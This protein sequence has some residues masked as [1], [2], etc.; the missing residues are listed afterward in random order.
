MH[1]DSHRFESHN[2]LIIQRR[3]ERKKKKY[4]LSFDIGF[5][6]MGRGW[7]L[8]I[9]CG[10]SSDSFVKGIQSSEFFSYFLPRRINYQHII[11]RFLPMRHW[12]G[13]GIEIERVAQRGSSS[14]K[15]Y[16]EVTF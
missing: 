13:R 7:R 10:A 1:P 9:S 3:S 2:S 15:A 4:L 16:D 11:L 5:L 6:L 14:L 12:T 8:V